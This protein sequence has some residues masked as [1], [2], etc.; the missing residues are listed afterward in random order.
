MNRIIPL[1]L[2]L[3]GFAGAAEAQVRPNLPDALSNMS[4]YVRIAHQTYADRSVV[5]PQGRTDRVFETSQPWE[6]IIAHYENAFATQAVLANGVTCAGSVR[7]DHKRAATA[8]LNLGPQQ[9]MLI[10]EEIAGG[11]RLT[12]WGALFG[13]PP[14]VPSRAHHQGFPPERVAAYGL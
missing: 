7:L 4:A 5:S 9:F 12:L 8:T 10:A 13:Q 11:T 3:V 1:A 6:Q 2:T 14:G